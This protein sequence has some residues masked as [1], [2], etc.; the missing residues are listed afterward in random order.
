MSHLGFLCFTLVILLQQVTLG[1]AFNRG[2][3]TGLFKKRFPQKTFNVLNPH[4]INSDVRCNGKME[5]FEKHSSS[6]LTIKLII[7]YSS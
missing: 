3:V 1:L 7:L 5:Y 6:K 2:D 4:E